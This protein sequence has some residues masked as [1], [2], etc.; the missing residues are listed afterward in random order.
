[1][2]VFDLAYGKFSEG[3]ATDRDDLSVSDDRKTS[4]TSKS[5]F[6]SKSREEDAKVLYQ[7]SCLLNKKGQK[8]NKVNNNL[9]TDE[10]KNGS[11]S[12]SSGFVS[13][14]NAGIKASTGYESREIFTGDLTEGE[15]EAF[16]LEGYPILNRGS[17]C[18]K[19]EER[20]LKRIRR[21]IK[22]K[23]SAQES[24]RKK[25]EYVESLEKRVDYV[26]S[27]N[28]VL[29]EQVDSLNNTVRSLLKELKR[30]QGTTSKIS[31]GTQSG[32]CLKCYLTKTSRTSPNKEYTCSND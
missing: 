5:S 24:R 17:P 16:L 8:K 18:T 32:T 30:I 15:R 19:S 27:E 20:A 2:D 14:D 28:S 25:K 22:N 7:I 21:K 3:M 26:N 11:D 12:E 13:L 23:L 6:L 4:P 29:R 10:D 9:H 31:R 1:M